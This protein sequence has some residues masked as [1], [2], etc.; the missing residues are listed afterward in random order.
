MRTK[1][2]LKVKTR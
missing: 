1:I 2:D